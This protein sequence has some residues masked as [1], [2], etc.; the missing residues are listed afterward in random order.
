MLTSTNKISGSCPSTFKSNSFPSEA[1]QIT[2]KSSYKVSN[3]MRPLRNN[4]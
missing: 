3:E 1:S 2:F 4:L